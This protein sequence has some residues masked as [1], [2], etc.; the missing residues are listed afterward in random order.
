MCWMGVHRCWGMLPWQ[1]IL[2]L[3]LL[4]VNDSDYAIGYRGGLSGQPTEYRY[5]WYP[6]PKRCCHSNRL[7]LSIFIWGAHWRHLANMTEPSTC[8]SDAALCQITLTTC[9]F[10]K[11]MTFLCCIYYLAGF[12]FAHLICNSS[13]FVIVGWCHKLRTADS[14]SLAACLQSSLIQGLFDKRFWNIWLAIEIKVI[15]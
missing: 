13:R 1:P 3:K 12:S 15:S 2:G 9:L 5:C 8:G 10:G 11:Q 7:W 4:L 14:C 6:A